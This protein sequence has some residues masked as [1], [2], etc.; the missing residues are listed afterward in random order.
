[1]KIKIETRLLFF[2]IMFCIVFLQ[3]GCKKNTDKDGETQSF[4]GIHE[5]QFTDNQNITYKLQVKEG[6]LQDIKNIDFKLIDKSELDSSILQMV[7][8]IGKPFSIITYEP[9]KGP[10]YVT[11]TI[12]IE[13]YQQFQQS[14]VRPSVYNINLQNT[15]KSIDIADFQQIDNSI[16]VELTGFSSNLKENSSSLG[17]VSF[18][19]TSVCKAEIETCADQIKVYL[20]YPIKTGSNTVLITSDNPLGCN[21]II[22]RYYAEIEINGN[23]NSRS[24][25]FALGEIVNLDFTYLNVARGKIKIMA[26]CP[27]LIPLTNWVINLKNKSFVI[28]NVT[29]SDVSQILEEF[30]PV[31]LFSKNETN[32][33][34]PIDNAFP[35][36][37]REE[38][39]RNFDDFSF[40]QSII[41][42]SGTAT[43]YGTATYCPDMND[44]MALSYWSFYSQDTKPLLGHEGD[45]EMVTIFV[46]N[47]I[48]IGVAFAQHVFPAVYKSWNEIQKFQGTNRPLIFIANGSHASYPNAGNYYIFDN[49][50]GQGVE[51]KDYVFNIMPRLTDINLF[52]QYN[53]LLYTGF[54]GKKGLPLISVKMP[55]YNGEP[56]KWLDPCKWANILN[57]QLL[58]IVATQPIINITNTS[59]TSGGNVTLEGMTPVTARGV[60]WSNS[61]NPVFSDNHTSNGSGAGSFTS[62]ITGLSPNTPYHIRAYA[63]NSS[64]TV[65][66]EDRTFTTTNGNPSGDILPLAVGNY[67]T[68]LPD[69]TTQTVTISIT[70]TI[71]IQGETCY[72]WFAQ[73]DQVEWYYKN[74]SDGC[75]A[76]GYSGPYQYPPDLE[77]KYPANSG[78]NWITNWIAVPVP[79]TM[80]C[81]S[82]NVT[83]ESYTG[84]Y[85]YHFMLPMKKD[86]FCTNLFKDE[87]KMKLSGLKTTATDG[88]DIYQYFVPGLG[89]VGWEN[90]FQGTRLYKVVLTDYHLN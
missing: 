65:Y 22:K 9:I 27:G 75:W 15:D 5:I 31:Y 28:D 66:G 56:E 42:T 78:D 90:Y 76:Y 43:I 11:I 6:C 36:N 2:I 37:L 72:K 33:P 87:L 89:M 18:M 19:G 44:V 16:I 41:N 24:D 34:I 45:W 13:L 12:P 84:C 81:E 48:P 58:P 29:Q 35:E 10:I 23:I 68:Y 3:A 70:G 52:N 46:K 83:F 26:K 21:S 79:T 50:D 60:C 39:I 40:P 63:T 77:Y 55:P 32:F 82:T 67:W 1:M 30:K 53:W 8:F 88:Y 49:A 80:T 7:E 57:T 4:N 86:N 73:G 47:S 20:N 54:V 25:D 74:K 69:I 85:K 62:N 51:L 38:Y 64:G 14:G 71:D 59:A 61:T 17:Q